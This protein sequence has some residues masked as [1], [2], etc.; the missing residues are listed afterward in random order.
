MEQDDITLYEFENL[1]TLTGIVHGVFTRQGGTSTG[2][3]DSLNVGMKSG[4]EHTA[5]AMNRKRITLKMGMNPM[6]FL[7]QVHGSDIKV[8]KKEHNDLSEVFEPGKELY[9]ADGIVTDMTGVF[10]VIQVADCQAVMLY[11]PEKRVVANVHSGWRG[12][13]AD[14]AGKCVDAMVSQFGCRPGDI[15][16]GISPSLGPCCAEFKNYRREFPE[17]LW[18]YK[19]P[20][21]PYFDFWR[22]TCDQLTAR[23]MDAGNI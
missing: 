18:Q 2:A 21:T 12:S 10:L 6:V 8:V 9:T 22:M 5:I 23:G 19:D 15:R 7:N 17:T 4:D 3:F 16:A 13:V 1:K 20:D 11:D 14:I